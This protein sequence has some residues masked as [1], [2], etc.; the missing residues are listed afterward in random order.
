MKVFR[1]SC[2]FLPSLFSFA[3]AATVTALAGSAPGQST[4]KNPGDHPAYSFEAEPHLAIDPYDP[5][6]IGPGFRGTFVVL[7]NGFVTSINNSI[8]IGVG[9][10]WIFYGGPRGCHDCDSSTGVV[11]PLVLQWNF[12]LHRNWS[13]FGE[14]GISFR[15]HDHEHDHHDE[16]HIDV[17]P[18][19]LFVGGRYHFDDTVALTLRLGSPWLHGTPFSLGVSFLL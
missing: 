5:D 8:G 3:A 4:I 1:F 14:P 12:W 17:D 10:D 15:F 18:F 7:D 19:V 11:V 6:G 16:G 2:R 9:A 13:V